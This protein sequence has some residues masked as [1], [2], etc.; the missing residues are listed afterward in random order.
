[1]PRLMTCA[2]WQSR[3]SESVSSVRLEPKKYDKVVPRAPKWVKTGRKR[4]D[5]KLKENEESD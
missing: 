3:S 4:Y 1:M 2:L 5:I